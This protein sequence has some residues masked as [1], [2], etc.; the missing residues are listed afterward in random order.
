MKYPILLIFSLIISVSTR[1][2]PVT[3]FDGIYTGQG[4]NQYLSLSQNSGYLF[5]RI[6]EWIKKDSSEDFTFLAWFKLDKFPWDP[7]VVQNMPIVYLS[8]K[9]LKCEIQIEKFLDCYQQ[10]PTTNFFRLSL[11]DDS[12]TQGQNDGLL[13]SL[14]QWYLVVLSSSSGASKLSLFDISF[15]GGSSGTDGPIKSV[16]KFSF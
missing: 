6:P 5:N 15:T 8:N 12:N 11:K 16:T 13:I 10:E 7:D 9:N 1:I 14:D 4:I 3:R 2:G